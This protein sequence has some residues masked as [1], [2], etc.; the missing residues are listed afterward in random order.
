[1]KRLTIVLLLLLGPIHNGMAAKF[2]APVG[3]VNDFAKILRPETVAQLET[4]L[5]S[6]A[7]AGH[8]ELTIV[9]LS[10]LQ[11][12]PIENVAVQLFEEWKIGKKGKDN[13]LLLLLAPNERKAKIEVGYGLEPV[14]PDALATR[15]LR[16]TLVPA[17]REG[18]YDAGILQ[19]A[20]ALLR[21][22][23][24]AADGTAAPNAARGKKRSRLSLVEVV[25]SLAALFLLNFLG[26]HRTGIHGTSWRGRGFHGGFPG[27]FHGGGFGGGGFGGFGGGSSGG[28]GG[29]ANW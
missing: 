4:T 10:S 6:A 22:L 1:M 21:R 12:E 27:G 14:L 15:I 29:S 13:G 16:E 23:R 19:C 17:F 3:Y 9:S 26:R 25:V 20:D 24:G 5:Q 2:P 28:G 18:R 7:Q 8:V 11:E